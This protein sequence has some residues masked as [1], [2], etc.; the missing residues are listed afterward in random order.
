MK[1]RHE[2]SAVT[3]NRMLLP[4]TADSE[5]AAA[6]LSAMREATQRERAGEYGKQQIPSP[7]DSYL[8][9]L[10][11]RV[12]SMSADQRDAFHALLTDDDADL[13]G[14]FAERMATHAVRSASIEPVLAGLLAIA[15][16]NQI[17]DRR[18][19]VSPLALLYRAA[20]ILRYD[21]APLFQRAAL[22]FDSE[23]SN[24]IR[25][26]PSRSAE[27]GRVQAFGYEE[28]GAGLTFEFVPLDRSRY[29]TFNSTKA[30]KLIRDRPPT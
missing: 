13:F 28:V 7:T 30:S 27:S 22:P 2:K 10:M 11:K 12:N 4:M 25:A 5:S 23:M 26:F 16:T 6:T 1:T 9:E 24:E 29:P 21:P 3:T 18:E 15:V 20:E 17:A 8:L 19:L 14:F